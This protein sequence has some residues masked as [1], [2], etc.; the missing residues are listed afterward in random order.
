MENLFTR[1]L[2]NSPLERFSLNS[3]GYSKDVTLALTN[4]CCPV[5]CTAVLCKCLAKHPVLYVVLCGKQDHRPNFLML[6]VGEQQVL[7]QHAASRNNC[8]EIPAAP[9]VASYKCCCNMAS[10]LNKRKSIL[11]F[12]LFL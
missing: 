4:T 2:C 1:T 5:E 3:K 6:C 12:V 10:R 11:L 8:S 7:R 9:C